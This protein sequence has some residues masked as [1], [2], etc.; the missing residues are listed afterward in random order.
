MI[1]RRVRR[2]LRKRLRRLLARLALPA[3]RVRHYAQQVATN[4]GLNPAVQPSHS[5]PSDAR[6]LAVAITHWRDSRTDEARTE[7]FV[8]VV[9]SAFSVDAASC[10]VI[11]HTNDP[12][13]TLE[14]LKA[15]LPRTMRIEVVSQSG[16]GEPDKLHKVDVCII[17]WRPSA[18]HRHGH[19]L[20]WTHKT[21]FRQLAQ[22]RRFS[23]LIYLEDDEKLENKHIDYWDRHRPELAELGLI[24]GYIRYEVRDGERFVVDQVRRQDTHC[25]PSAHTTSGRWLQLESPYQGWHILDRQLQLDFLAGS[26]SKSPVMSALLSGNHHQERAA[27]GPIFDA[28]PAGFHA[29]NVV[30]VEIDNQR[31]LPDEACLIRHA[32]D[33]YSALPGY[34]YGTIRVEDLFAG[35][36]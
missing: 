1:S 29:R 23:H 16:I 22:S 30:R 27:A 26:F 15:G 25:L 31:L 6:R 20:T 33:T 13:Q 24:P 19:F 4:T 17:P 21:S 10:N 36:K 32:S 18:F 9:A 3:W 34:A 11:V 12:D 2:L 7:T 14:Q 5:R 28:V 8:D 35:P